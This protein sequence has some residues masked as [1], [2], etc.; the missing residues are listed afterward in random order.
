MRCQKP[1][2][3][4][5]SDFSS[6]NGGGGG[7]SSNSTTAL[8]AIAL[9]PVLS[10]TGLVEVTGS[11]VR[12][13]RHPSPSQAATPRPAKDWRPPMKQETFSYLRNNRDAVLGML[14]ARRRRGRGLAA[15][16]A[17]AYILYFVSV[18]LCEAA[19]DADAQNSRPLASNH[20]IVSYCPTS[21]RLP[22]NN[23]RIASFKNKPA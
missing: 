16:Q 23:R 2:S 3:A 7:G 9:P 8:T 14:G 18:P 17:S 20:A 21:L 12:A 1:V 4:D 10:V 6:S 22:P 11:P 19:R 13:G 15:K 5:I